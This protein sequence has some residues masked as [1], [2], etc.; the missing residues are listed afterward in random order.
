MIEM[1]QHHKETIHEEC[2][3]INQFNQ[4]VNN[5]NSNTSGSTKLSTTR[6]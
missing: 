5:K 4:V 2:A 1:E 3:K 6:L